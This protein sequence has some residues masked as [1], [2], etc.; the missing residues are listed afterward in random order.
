MELP[1][2]DKNI[3]VQATVLH[4]I[5]K[6]QPDLNIGDIVNPKEILEQGY[7]HAFRGASIGKGLYGIGQEIEMNLYSGFYTSREL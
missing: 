2:M 5:A 6:V 3:L 4:D 7:L 1:G